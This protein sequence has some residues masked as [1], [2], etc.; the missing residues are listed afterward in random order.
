MQTTFTAKRC[1]DDNSW[2]AVGRVVR[3]LAH[4]FF[5]CSKKG[6]FENQIFRR[7][8]RDKQFRKQNEIGFHSGCLGASG[9]CLGQVSGDIAMMGLSCATAIRSMARFS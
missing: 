7:I 5:A 6:W 9:A 3:Q 8:A 2:P 1:P 4:R